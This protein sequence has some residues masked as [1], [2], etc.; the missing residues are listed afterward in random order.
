[1]ATLVLKP[2]FVE[3]PLVANG[4]PPGPLSAAAENLPGSVPSTCVKQWLRIT[5]RQIGALTVY[6]FELQAEDLGI[7]AN[8]TSRPLTGSREDYVEQLYQRIEDRWVSTQ[9][10][11]EQFG[12]EL[13]ALGGELFDELIPA[14]FGELLWT[15]RNDLRN[16]L[17]LSDEPFI[18]WEIVHLKNGSRKL[19]AESWFLGRLGAMRWFQGV[20]YPPAELSLKKVRYSRSTPSRTSCFPARRRR[21]S[22]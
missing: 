15:R 12:R 4:R 10:D 7:L 13:K 3:G 5:E 22:S 14:E 19:P 17:I 8:G 11:R 21:R 1:M 2:E 16:I 18:P 20:G 9:G 6:D